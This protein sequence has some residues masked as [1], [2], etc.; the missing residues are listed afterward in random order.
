LGPI[1]T[2]FLFDMTHSYIAAFYLLLVISCI[3]FGLLLCLRVRP[4]IL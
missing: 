3:A 2:G 1:L 4:K